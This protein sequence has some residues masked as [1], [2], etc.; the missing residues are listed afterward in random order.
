MK[1]IHRSALLPAL[2]TGLLVLVLG[3]CQPSTG[4]TDVP[5]AAPVESYPGGVPPT[6]VPIAPADAYPGGVRPTD[7]PIPTPE[8]YPQ[9]T[10]LRGAPAVGPVA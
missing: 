5:D 10:A 4:A 6:D 9:P 7:V 2:A 3:A 8:A 1:P